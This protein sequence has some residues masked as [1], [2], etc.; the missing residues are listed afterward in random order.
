MHEIRLVLSTILVASHQAI[1]CL[2]QTHASVTNIGNAITYL[3]YA[4][5]LMLHL[6]WCSLNTS[7]LHWQFIYLDPDFKTIFWSKIIFNAINNLLVNCYRKCRTTSTSFT[8]VQRVK[9]H[10]LS[11]SFYYW[12]ILHI[13]SHLWLLF[14]LLY[15]FI[16]PNL[17]IMTIFPIFAHS[18]ACRRNNIGDKSSRKSWKSEDEKNCLFYC[19]GGQKWIL[20][21]NKSKPWSSLK[22]QAQFRG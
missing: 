4:D 10:L 6:S 13:S 16:N 19:F 5:Q 17:K 2:L 20:F 21:N 18:S 15:K 8:N 1:F 9:S 7:F 3:S 12:W 14:W 11:L 22:H